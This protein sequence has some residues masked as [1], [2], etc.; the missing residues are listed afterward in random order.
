MCKREYRREYSDPSGLMQYKKAII[1]NTEDAKLEN[2]TNYGGFNLV[3]NEEDLTALQ[4]GRCIAMNLDG[5]YVAF[6]TYKK[7]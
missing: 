2:G 6:I 4:E 1:S 3:L 7:N 5:E